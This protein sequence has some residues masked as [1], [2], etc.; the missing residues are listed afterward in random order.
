MVKVRQRKRDI[1][2][3]F[4]SGSEGRLKQQENLEVIM[5]EA[6]FKD[7]KSM[8]VKLAEDGGEMELSADTFFINTGERP[9]RPKLPGLD[10][11]EQARVLD[12][13]S[14][15]E[16]GEVPH[17]LIVLGG[18]YIGLEFGQLFRRL[19]SRVT[20]VQRGKQLV[21]REDHEVAEAM[22]EVL[23]GEGIKVSRTREHWNTQCS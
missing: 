6:S 17:H 18:G 2:N 1:V 13:T 7:S 3:T 20:V 22:R 8:T 4:R 19:G 15:M 21:P 23:E 14:I 16:L 5:G 11:L 12:S 10:S 9:S